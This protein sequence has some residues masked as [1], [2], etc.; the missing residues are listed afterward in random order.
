MPVVFSV[1]LRGF[2]LICSLPF[3]FGRISRHFFHEIMR[4]SAPTVFLLLSESTGDVWVFYFPAGQS[5]FLTIFFSEGLFLSRVAVTETHLFLL[6]RF[7]CGR[8]NCLAIEAFPP[9]MPE[10]AAASLVL[11]FRCPPPVIRWLPLVLGIVFLQA[12]ERWTYPSL[13]Y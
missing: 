7:C 2:L 13:D 9:P 8:C 3:L 12:I 1:P 6:F 11:F 10:S 5:F 4:F